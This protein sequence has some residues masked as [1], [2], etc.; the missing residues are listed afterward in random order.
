VTT[1]MNATLEKVLDRVLA[2]S[3]AQGLMRRRSSRQLAVLA[4][5]GIDDPDRFATQLDWLARESQ[6]VSL[7]DVLAAVLHGA[8]LPERAVLITFDDGQRNVFDVGLPLLRERGIPAVVYVV[9]GLLDTDQ[10][11]WWT[12][13]EALSRAGGQGGGWSGPPGRP[14]V[15]ALKH[16]PDTE[17]VAA[18][19]ELR[20]T[21]P[22]PPPRVAQLRR[23]ELPQFE[24][25]SVAVGNHSLSHA[26]LSRCSDDKI[27][28]EVGEAHRILTDALGHPPRSFAYPDGQVDGRATAAVGAA[29]YDVA[30]LFDHQ[31]TDLPVTSPLMMSRLRMNTTNSLDRSA[32]I[33][34]GFHSRLHRGIGR[35]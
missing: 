16:R 3:P 13:V 5:H 14:L 30:F 35:R 29:G 6:P 27:G 26:C 11:F 12:E 1:E 25:A 7:D 2:R 4:Y 24:A 31:V 17:R 23:D 10:P 20:R 34:S 32:I 22:E 21:S 33:V 18:I 8:P 19:E 15:Q 28:H 9:A